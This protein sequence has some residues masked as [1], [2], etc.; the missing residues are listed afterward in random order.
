MTLNTIAINTNPDW[1][2]VNTNTKLTT[3][4][5][6]ALKFNGASPS[7]LQTVQVPIVSNQ[8][9]KQKYGANDIFTP[10][11]ICAGAQNKD[12]CQGTYYCINVIFF[13]FFF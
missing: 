11:N 7:Q 5:L 2:P 1:P 12:S 9:C 3:I 4:G 6:G 13:F 10:G 8:V